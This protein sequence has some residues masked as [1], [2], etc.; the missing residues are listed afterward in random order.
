MV[1]RGPS[2]L[3]SP[4]NG[5]ELSPDQEHTASPTKDSASPPPVFTRTD[6]PARSLSSSSD[7]DS[8]SE[9]DKPHE[10]P[11]LVRDPTEIMA[12]I[13]PHHTRHTLESMVRTCK[14]DVVRSIE[15][16][17]HARDAKID[18]SATALSSLSCTP[19]PPAAPPGAFGMQGGKSAFYP[20][21]VSPAAAGGDSLYG[22]SPRLGVS[23]LRLTYSPAGGGVAGFMSPCIT[24]GLMPVF[25][26]RPPLDSY[27]FPGMIRDFS[28][29]QSKESLCSAGLYTQPNS[30][31]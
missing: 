4:R 13:F 16:L 27:S 5:K 10:C 12:K 14:G 26:L 24:P 7:P 11:S 28:Y 15:L 22:L 20:L 30:E 2:R 9:A 17:L 8:G 3:P 25:P 21:H 1:T 23:P 29:F 6:S 18:A 19:R 31:K